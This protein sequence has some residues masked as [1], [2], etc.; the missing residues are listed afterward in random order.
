MAMVNKNVE[1]NFKSNRNGTDKINSI[2]ENQT[3]INVSFDFKRV[4]VVLHWIFRV[5]LCTCIFKKE[6]KGSLIGAVAL[7]RAKSLTIICDR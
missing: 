6:L 5:C 2:S 4:S 1:R 7:N 3:K